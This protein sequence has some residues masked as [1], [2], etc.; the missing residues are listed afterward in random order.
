MDDRELRATGGLGTLGSVIDGLSARGGTPALVAFGEEGVETLSYS[1]LAGR[2]R[3]LAR[4][5][6]GVGVERG[7]HVAIVC[8]N[9][10][11]WIAACLAV[12]S[13]GAV[14]VPMDVHIGDYALGHVLVDSGAGP[15]FTAADQAGRLENLGIVASSKLILLDAGEEDGRSW[16]CLPASGDEDLPDLQAG[17]GAALFYTSG[18]TGAAK[19]VP[20]SHANLAFQIDSLLGTDLVYEEGRVLL[21]LPLHHVYPFVMG[22]LTSLAAGLPI[23]LPRSLTGPDLVRALQEG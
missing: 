10:P 6:R 1:E 9:R 19:G 16:R 23:V 15:V 20:L 3:H 8:G 22:M 18:T 21:P 5:L 2:V 17:D 13:A 7:D 4:G 11:D 12:I 14:V